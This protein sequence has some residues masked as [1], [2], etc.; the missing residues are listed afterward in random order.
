MRILHSR[1]KRIQIEHLLLLISQVL[2]SSAKPIS[3][4]TD[5]CCGRGDLSLLLAHYFPALAIVSIDLKN[6][7]L[8]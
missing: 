4:I 3:S 6:Q 2:K 1:R 5:F 7:S 8:N